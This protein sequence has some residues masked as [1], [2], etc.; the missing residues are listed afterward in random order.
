HVFVGVEAGPPPER[1]RA[2]GAAIRAADPHVRATVTRDGPAMLWQRG[3]VFVP[4]AALTAVYRATWGQV[5]RSAAARATM[6]ALA[7]EYAAVAAAAGYPKG[8]GVEPATWALRRL[9]RALDTS[10]ARDY[11]ARDRGEPARPELDG[12]IG[13]LL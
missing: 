9:P 4:L 12:K 8:T 7:A 2:L 5:L 10:L 11:A 3:A 13:C 1:V 6:D